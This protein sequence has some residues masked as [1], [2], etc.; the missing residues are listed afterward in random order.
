MTDRARL[1][2]ELGGALVLAAGLSFGFLR[3]TEGGALVPPPGALNPEVTQAN[4]RETICR[5]G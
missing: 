5:R 3:L 2:A 4:I 1:L